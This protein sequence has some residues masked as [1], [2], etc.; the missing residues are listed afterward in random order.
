MLLHAPLEAG[1]KLNVHKS[2]KRLFYVLC[3]EGL[4]YKNTKKCF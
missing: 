2:D 4:V 3:P 1:R